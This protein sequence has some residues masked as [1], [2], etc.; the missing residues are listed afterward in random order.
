MTPQEEIDALRRE[1]CCLKSQ[2]QALRRAT[3]DAVWAAVCEAGPI[4]RAREVLAE[5]EEEAGA[6]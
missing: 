1:I 4:E 2:L 3:R 6:A 5:F